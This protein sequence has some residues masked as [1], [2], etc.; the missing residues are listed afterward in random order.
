MCLYPRVI[1]N[2]KYRRNK[3]N[4]GL[5]PAVRDKRIQYIPIGCQ[6]CIE[7]RK[8]K[9]RDWQVRLHED[10]KEHQNGKFVTLT[11]STQEIKKLIRQHPQWA[12]LK[13]YDVD[14]AM[15]IRSVRLFLERWRKQFGKSLRHWLITELGHGTTEHI[16][17]HGIVWTDHIEKLEGIWQYGIVWKGYEVNDKIENYVNAR[18]VNYIMKY[19]TKVDTQHLNFVPQILCSPGIG[20]HYEKSGHIQQNKYKGKKTIEFYRTSTGHKISMPIYWRN[21]IYNDWE[22]EELWIQKL[23]KNERWICGEKIPG[24]DENTYYNVLE[25][26]RERTIKLGYQ[27]P[28]FIWSKRKYEEERREL[29]RKKRIE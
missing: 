19:V 27:T 16:H 7:C 21:K 10:I 13:G 14:Y 1:R 11:Y 25:Y 20:R 12:K 4:G 17:L 15:V 5:I 6:V 8:Q 26:H 24:D 3:K 28:E 29:L 18:T 9:A 23:D 2:P 22:R